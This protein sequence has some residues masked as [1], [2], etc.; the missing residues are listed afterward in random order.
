MIYSTIFRRINR[1]IHIDQANGKIKLETLTKP[2]LIKLP[3]GL[4]KFVSQEIYIA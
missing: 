2:A 1:S 3:M 4:T